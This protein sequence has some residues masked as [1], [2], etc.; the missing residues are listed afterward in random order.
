MHGADIHNRSRTIGRDLDLATTSIAVSAMSDRQPIDFVLC[1]V[2][3]LSQLTKSIKILL[4]RTKR[5]EVY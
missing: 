1:F 4:T 3:E 5:N 2:I